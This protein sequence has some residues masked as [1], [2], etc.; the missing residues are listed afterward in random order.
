LIQAVPD[1]QAGAHDE[2]MLIATLD[3]LHV[4]RFYSEY[5]TCNRLAFATR[6]RMVCATLSDDLHPGFDRYLPYRDVVAADPGAAYVL[7]VGCEAARAFTIHLR[8][9]RAEADVT[10]VAGYRIYR[11]RSPVDVP[12]RG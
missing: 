4:S 12:R 11:P 5:W 9:A 7:P 3:R 10:E 6:E 2:R 1:G 8:T